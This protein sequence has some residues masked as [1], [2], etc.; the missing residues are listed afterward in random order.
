VIVW[1][2]DEGRP[3]AVVAY[4]QRGPNGVR[5]FEHNLDEVCWTLEVAE[6]PGLP[7]TAEKPCV[8]RAKEEV[9]SP[10][11]LEASQQKRTASDAE[12]A[13]N[14]KPKRAVSAWI[15]WLNEVGRKAA[16]AKTGK[17]SLK[18]AGEMWK[19]LSDEEK[20]PWHAK[21][22]KDKARYT[23]EMASCVPPDPPKKKKKGK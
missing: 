22:E 13:A 6:E 19:K 12:E 18:A 17:T 2:E 11:A 7:E 16:T 15:L 3:R 14:N 1:K 5:S 23:R 10:E 9:A 21:A 20:K 4:D 8:H